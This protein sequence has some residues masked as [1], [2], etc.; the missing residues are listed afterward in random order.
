MNT[1]FLLTFEMRNEGNV[2]LYHMIFITQHMKGLKAMKEAVV[3][4]TQEPRQFSMSDYK[5]VR[6]KEQLDLVFKPAI[7]W[8]C[9]K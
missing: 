5:V 6:K 3:K 1:K 7:G 4:D 2:R 9:I 8:R